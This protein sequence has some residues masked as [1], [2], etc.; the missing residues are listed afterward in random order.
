[1]RINAERVRFLIAVVALVAVAGSVV[2]LGAHSSEV[3]APMGARSAATTSS[4]VAVI[5]PLPDEVSNGTWSILDASGST[6]SVGFI[7]NYTW[8][9][10]HQ[11][12]TTYSYAKMQTFKFKDLGLY[13]IT[14][15][16]TDNN[17]NSSTAFTAVYSILDSDGDMLPDWWEMKYFKNLNQTGSGDYDHDG[18]T[19]LEEYAAGTDPT[20]KNPQPSLA[21]ELADNWMYLAA[22]AAVIVVALIILIPRMKKKQ[23]AEVK[24]KIEAAIE[25]E[26]ALESDE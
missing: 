15:T 24:K 7:S 13:K 22:I 19:N 6:D 8:S 1:M 3:R 12:T 26:K 11:A 2:V 21:S 25:I 9:I 18:Y 16:V 5:A 23:T 20:V 17:G 14:L 4:V 10:A